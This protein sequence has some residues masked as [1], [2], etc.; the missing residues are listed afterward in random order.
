MQICAVVPTFNEAGNIGRLVRTLR[1]AV[2]GISMLIVDDNSPDRTAEVVRRLASEMDGID[3]LVREGKLGFGTAYLDGF[4]RL[5]HAGLP[6]A[7]LMMDG[8][9][10]HDPYAVPAMIAALAQCDV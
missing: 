1:G 10:S 2:P 8:D 6:D 4:R 7:V 9:L 3:L 5:E